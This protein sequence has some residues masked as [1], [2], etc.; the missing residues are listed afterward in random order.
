VRVI[1]MSAPEEMIEA[2]EAAGI[3]V[4]HLDLVPGRRGPFDACRALLRSVRLLRSLRPDA[5]ICF[6]YL[7]NVLGKVAGRLAGVPVVI[8]SIRNERFGSRMRERLERATEVL[9]DVTTTNS[10][11]AGRSLVARRV[12]S[13]ERL[14]VIPNA[15]EPPPDAEAASSTPDAIAGAE[16][17]RRTAREELGVGPAEFL[18]LAVGTLTEQKDYPT[19]WRAFAKLIR[20]GFPV[21]LA[22]AGEGDQ[23]SQLEQL[24]RELNLEGRL[25][26]LGTR[27]DVP[28][29]LRAAD[30]YVLSS[31]W[32]GLPNS[33]MEAAAAG[34]PCVATRVGGVEEVLTGTESGWLVGPSAVDE[35]ARAMREVFL[36]DVQRREYRASRARSDVLMAYGPAA[37]ASAWEKVLEGVP[38]HSSRSR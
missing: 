3:G 34:L 16:E 23:R 20:E 7:A 1:S 12:V 21:R 2:F 6:C 38:D 10:R 11:I 30:A 14:V 17:D 9:A 28:R 18:W 25:R 8:A 22:V 24:A 19:L 15:L 36:C 31:A 4:D 27:A 35:L 37:A 13:E 26:L 29:L 5:L 33:L 32:E